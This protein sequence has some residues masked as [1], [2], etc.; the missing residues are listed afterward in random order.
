MED[1]ASRMF[2]RYEEASGISE[3]LC[4]HHHIKA[5]GLGK[6]GRETVDGDAQ[7]VER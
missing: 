1:V 6:G 2:P 3:S 7:V 5:K 4:S